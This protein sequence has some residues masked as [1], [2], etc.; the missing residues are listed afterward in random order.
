[1]TLQKKILKQFV[2]SMV[3]CCV[4]F[5]FSLSQLIVEQTHAS[6]VGTQFQLSFTITFSIH[7]LTFD[8]QTGYDI[9]HLTNGEYTS[10]IGKPMMPL[11]NARIALPNGMTATSVY[12]L[13]IQEQVI[14]GKFMMYPAQ[15]AQPVG[16][17]REEIPFVQPDV[18]T[19]QSHQQFPAKYIELIGQNDLAGQSMA[20]II[21]YPL[22]YLPAEQK[23]TLITSMTFRIEGTGGYICGDYLPM[24][25]SQEN[26][27]LYQQMIQ[28]WVIN[29]EEV[30]LHSSAVPQQMG[31]DPGDYDYVIITQESWVSEFQPL[32]QWKTKKGIPTAIVTTA[33]IY[34]EGGYSGSNVD[35]IKAFVE[36]AYTNWGTIYVLLGGD[37][38]V[39][40]CHY[41]TFPSVDSNPVANDVY[42]A[43]FDQDWICEVNIGRASV[44]GPGSST[45]Q[46]GNFI[47]KILNYETN[48]PL[49]DY[50]QKAGFFGFDLDGSTHTEQCKMTINSSYIPTNWI[51]TTVYD[52]QGGNHE[53]NVI[54]VINAGQNL[55]NHADHSS[56]DYM[57]TGYVN[58]GSGLYNPDMDNLINGNKQGIIYSMGCDPAAY[59]TSNCI[60]EHFVRNSNGG[61]IAFIGN[62]RYGW[63]NPG[64]LNTL[65]LLYDKYF[66][67][68]LFQENLYNLG[69]CFSDHKNDGYEYDAYYQYCYTELTLLGDPELPIWTED[70]ITLTGAFPSQIPTGSS[71]FIV[72]VTS[73]GAPVDQAYVCLWKDTE[74]YET[75]YT[76]GGGQITFTVA[77]S[78]QGSMFV[79]ITKHNYLPFEGSSLVVSGSNNPPQIPSKPNGSTSGQIDTEFTY[80]TSTIDPEADQVYYKWSWGNGESD[81]LG[82]YASGANISAS[83]IWPVGGTYEVKVKA[84][85]MLNAESGWSSGLYVMINGPKPNLNIGTFSGGFFE[86]A[87]EVKNTGEAPATNVQWTITI[88]NG[89]MFAGQLQ[90]GNIPT[91]AIGAS[92]SLVDSPILGFGPVVITVRVT[93]DGIPEMI[94][95][96]NG[97]ILLVY[98]LV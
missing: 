20:D 2:F 29:P 45:G 36:D 73:D 74:V 68:S 64:N 65:S 32:Q 95:T 43:D 61:G 33:W 25:I 39:I 14:N 16:T 6:D 92:Q 38:D 82:P 60:G 27:K 35:K 11:K 8:T 26:R 70:P 30:L 37:T 59:D 15:P 34:D 67:R 77:P 52:S 12:L 17:P 40:P 76:D 63:Y 54:E 57:G 3:I 81:W 41:K 55:M 31:V 4:A 13:D 50:V 56:N 53:S 24:S 87:S 96:V 66:F 79:T 75:G 69:A 78:T 84:K 86:V 44:T 1:M 62:S 97:F 93:A 46:I 51:T 21:I 91:L 5:S 80:S 7:D 48:P 42:Y 83:H 94:K 47:N 10:D 18:Q 19:Y 88:T 23:V 85:D 28:Q 9:I 98:A 58:H 72:T 22:H 90:T 71:G 49:T 89:I